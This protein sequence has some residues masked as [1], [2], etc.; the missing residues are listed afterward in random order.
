MTY[1][2]LQPN[3]TPTQ[4]T[5]GDAVRALQTQYNTN[6]PTATPLKVDGLYGPLTAAAL[7]PMASTAT[8]TP[9]GSNLGVSSQVPIVTSGPS[10]ISYNNNV[11]TLNGVNNALTDAQVAAKNAAADAGN[12]KYADAQAGKTTATTDTTTTPKTTPVSTITNPDG[13]TI[14]KNADGSSVITYSDGTS[15]NIAP[16]VDVTIAKMG[17]DNIRDLKASSNTLKTTMDNALAYENNDPIAIQAAQQISNTY[18][19]LIKTMEAKNNILGGM[20]DVSIARYGGLGI[21]N[22]QQRTSVLQAGV[23]R[24]ADLQQKKIDAINKSNA[25]YK[26]GDVK[27]F[28]EASKAYN[29]SLKESQNAINDLQK[30]INDQIKTHDAEIKQAQTQIRQQ[31]IDDHNFATQNAR[32]IATTL[33][34][35]GITDINSP[36]AQAILQDAANTYGISNP[37]VLLSAVENEQIKMQKEDATA[38]HQEIVDNKLLNPTSKA[39]KVVTTAQLNYAKKNNPYV[40]ADLTNTKAELDSYIKTAKVFSKIVNTDFKDKK[41]LGPKGYFTYD[42]GNKLINALPEGINVAGFVKANRDKF[43]KHLDS[44]GLSQEDID[45]INS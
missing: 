8:I 20:A 12:S 31:T 15:Y 10:K 36:K 39:E 26:A 30:T 17:Y 25:A 35:S 14:G 1:T 34:N 33:K 9:G 2:P 41:N 6:N 5:S 19:Q 45:K 11:S 40:D 23:A 29:N 27:A 32:D 38:R 43:D 18:D 22:E 3:Q 16:G 21:M 42:Y 24:V 13:S 44:Y 4:G 37:S 7:K 28:D